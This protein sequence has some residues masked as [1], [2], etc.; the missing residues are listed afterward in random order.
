MGRLKVQFHLIYLDHASTTPLSDGV[1]K[2]M[3]EAMEGYGN[4]SSLHQ[5]GR[6]VKS[7]VESARRE[8]ALSL[9]CEPAE[10]FFTSGAT[11]SLNMA[12]DA[13][14]DEKKKTR[15]FCSPMEHHAVLDRVRHLAE[16]GRIEWIEIANDVHGHLDTSFI[17]EAEAGDVVVMMAHNNE[18]GRANPIDLISKRSREKDLVF[19]CDAVQTASWQPIDLQ[20]WSGVQGLAI[21]AHKFNGPKGV[22]VLFWRSARSLRALL[23]GGSQERSLRPGTENV[24]GISGLQRAWRELQ[25]EADLRREQ[26]AALRK[27]LGDR[28]EQG[29]PIQCT[30]PFQAGDHPGIANLTIPFEGKTSMLL[31]RLDMAGICVSEGSACSSGSSNGSHVIRALGADRAGFASVRISFSHLNRSEELM[32]AL[33]T[34]EAAIAN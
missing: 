20:K 33:D 21:S 25:D 7:R 17:E 5:A 32:F 31:F 30:V 13:S 4:P 12:L 22:G 11:E 28:L 1:K 26:L 19:L 18:L 24:I 14:L 34:M 8:L 27:V 16:R 29:G 15:V 6:Q 10:I 23:H 3:S 2:A 9:S